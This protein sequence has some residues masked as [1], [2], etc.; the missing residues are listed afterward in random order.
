MGGPLQEI[1]VPCHSIQQSKISQNINYKY[2]VK[3]FWFGKNVHQIL[4][5]KVRFLILY[6]FCR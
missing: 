6:K 4:E 2:N 3:Y 5:A 1:S